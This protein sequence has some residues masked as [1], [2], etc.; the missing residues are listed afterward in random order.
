MI[1]K[2]L[3]LFLL[4]SC[5]FIKAQTIT[6]QPAE[7]DE[8]TEITLT[9]SGIDV[10]SA[11]G[12]SDVYLWAW[13][14]DLNDEYVGNS[15]QTG[16]NFGSSPETAK[17]TNNGDGTYSF[18]LTPD[19]FYATTGIGRVGFLAKS[20]NGANQTADFLFEVGSFEVDLVSPAQSTTIV[21]AGTSFNIQASSNLDADY[22][23]FANGASINASAEALSYNYNYTVNENIQFELVVTQSGDDAQIIYDFNAYVDPAPAEAALPEGMEDG[24]NYDPTNP[25]EATFVLYAPKKEFVHIM[26]NFNGNDWS[27]DNTYLMNYDPATDRFWLTVDLAANTET[28]LLYQYLVEYEINIADPYSTTVLDPYNDPYIEASVY[29]NIP[30]YPSGKTTEMVSYVQLD[31]AAYDWQVE[32]FMPPAKDD[33]V[34]YELLIRDFDDA[35]SFQSIIDR[36]DYLENLGINA[37]ELM[38]V[39][40]FDGNI[41]WG[42]NPAFHMALDKYYGTRNAF[43][44]LIDACHARGIAVILDVVYNHATGQN[45]YFRLYN[46]S[47][48]ATSG[49]PAADSPA[50]NT[51]ATH[52]YSVFNDF[53]HTK[54]LTKH[55][56]ERTATYWINEFNVDGFRW[57]LTKGFTQNCSGSETCTNAYNADRVAVLKE[58]ADFQWEADDDFFVIF[59]HLGNG[60]SLTEEQEWA[61]YRNDEGKGIMLWDIQNHQYNEATMGYN[62]G[63]NF[64]GIS[65]EV[66][67][68][69]NPAAV[70]Y[71][72]SH[73][74]ERLMY[75]NLAYG[76]SNG[77]YNVKNESTALAR[78]KAAGA[79]F[80]TVP[81]PKMIWQFGEL[82]YDISIFS[83]EDGS[84]PDPYGDGSCKLSPKPDGWDYLSSPERMD[85]YNTWAKLIAY[86]HAE[87]I[88]STDDFT[89]DAARNNG[90]K[91]IQLTDADAVTGKLKYVNIIGNFGVIEQVIDPQFQETGTWYNLMDGSSISVDNVNTGIM[92]QPGEYKMYGN[93]NASLSVG[94]ITKNAPF[95]IY[96]NP[97]KDYFII[98]KPAESL[99]IYDLSGKKIKSKKDLQQ[100]E[101]VNVSGLVPGIYI[102]NIKAADM[103]FTT[104]FIKQ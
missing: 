74:E 81:G 95:V 11:W 70:G 93:E 75:K 87:P 61:S 16:S 59:E 35:H 48:G 52:S 104:K 63:S 49:T 34:I 68:Y 80:F 91:K 17:W 30:A 89:I 96:P 24:F 86:K 57:D 83:C 101:D 73:D 6:V 76:N 10:A 54:D 2:L 46:T 97:G 71:M 102:I 7:F 47:N 64:N 36:L 3:L 99:D 39:Q 53:N 78:M 85:I 25:D 94:E 58:Y 67:G 5:T 62:S 27:V 32:D 82:G 14:Y 98:S 15:P 77:A 65:Y 38:P 12:T 69:S 19:D 45:P 9:L 90:L 33:L 55:Y 40:E 1:K 31:E 100:G 79:F 8:D 72:E 20:Q 88:F 28:D 92:L 13:Y 4:F 50:F 29:A 66:K 103:L 23:L 26:G 60:G 37:I 43:K 84:I 56:V 42:Y 22:E 41:S 18:V 44:S 21:T 51:S